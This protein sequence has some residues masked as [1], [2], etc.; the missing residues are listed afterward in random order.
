LLAATPP[1]GIA[2]GAME[3][4]RPAL[5][6]LRECGLTTEIDEGTARKIMGELLIID[7]RWRRGKYP[8]PYPE[9]HSR[10]HFDAAYEAIAAGV[11]NAETPVEILE[12][13]IPAMV[14]AFKTKQQW[15][16]KIALDVL[17][18]WLQGS[19]NEWKGKRLLLQASAP[20]RKARAKRQSDGEEKSFP[21]RAAWL[22]ERLR[23]RVWSQNDIARHG[24]P[25]PKTVAKILRGEPVREDVL[26]RLANVLSK[27]REKVDFLSVPN[28]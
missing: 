22:R 7:G 4:E 3:P 23:E 2:K 6:Q 17:K 15:L 10:G 20:Q 8:P 28:D 14:Q 16:P 25:D 26:E 19:I 9:G 24:G 12:S 5:E 1:W 18:Q 21:G 13:M 27:K 11:V